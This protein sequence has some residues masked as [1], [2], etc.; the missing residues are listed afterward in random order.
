VLRY[1]RI[2]R[3]FRN[4]SDNKGVKTILQFQNILLVH[5]VLLL[6]RPSSNKVLL[7]RL[8]LLLHFSSGSIAMMLWLPRPDAMML[9]FQRLRL[10]RKLLGM[11]A[12]VLNLPR[13]LLPTI[14]LSPM[15]TQTGPALACW[16]PC[17]V[18]PRLAR[19]CSNDL[20]PRGRG[21]N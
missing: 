12:P 8:L 5:V 18:C 19:R 17:K 2:F 9:I 4:I 11:H 16:G 15:T 14:V 1:T 6:V 13:Q 3:L 21:G 20:C 10:H 7:L